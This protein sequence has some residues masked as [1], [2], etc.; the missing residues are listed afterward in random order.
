MSENNSLATILY[1]LQK[2]YSVFCVLN[3]NHYHDAYSR[4]DVLIGL[5]NQQSCTQ[6][7][8]FQAFESQ[9][10]QQWKFGFWG[11]DIK[12]KLEHLNSDNTD[13]LHFPELFF[14]IPETVL[15]VKDDELVIL[16]SSKPNNPILKEI[17]AYSLI[18]TNQT[19]QLTLQQRVS[20]AA[21]LEK[22]SAIQKHIQRGDVYEL[23]FCMEFFAEEASINP[24]DTYLQLNRLSP[25]PFSAFLKFDKRYILSASPERYLQG[26][27]QSLISQPIK[28]TA[29]R[30]TDPQVDAKNKYNLRHSQ[31]EQSENVMIVDL[32]RND[33]SR[34]AERG[35]VQVA[36]LCAIYSFP[37][38]HQM[39]S[40]ISCKIKPTTNLKTIISQSFP[41]GSMTGAP[42]IAAMQLIEKY[43]LSKR[44]AYSGALGY[45]T[46]GNDFDFNVIIRSILYD[47]D[48]Q[49]LSFHVGSAITA[50]SVAAREYE[51]CLLKASAMMYI[52]HKKGFS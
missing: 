32:V 43:E 36:E 19:P 6:W 27:E 45:I 44:G 41:M 16:Y 28:G 40:T 26:Y 11:Y 10:T 42:K 31:K 4:Y 33:L 18:S 46:P 23:N 47:A 48:Q 29:A 51:E 13:T 50:E 24:V 2:H 21:Y 34:F 20:K 35:S 14:F 8:Y 15:A 9:N 7:E 52:L 22:I 38:W 3:S 17:N 1:Y 30:N 25:T 49:K 5:G 12:N 37:Q 39:I